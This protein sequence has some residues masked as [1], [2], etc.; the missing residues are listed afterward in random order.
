MAGTQFLC[1]GEYLLYKG[2]NTYSINSCETIELFYDIRTNLEKLEYAAY[3]T[4]IIN[5]VTTEN[6]NTYKILQLFLN[7]LYVISKTDKNMEFVTS[8][9][10]IRLMSIIGFKPITNSCCICN[11][12]IEL[13]YFS[14]EDSGV[15]C[16]NCG[17]QDKSAIQISKATLDALRYIIMADCKKIYSFEIPDEAKKELEIIAKLYLN[18]KLEQEY[19]M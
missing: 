5:D 6:Q 19:K 12:N 16:N 2:N 18:E 3:I 9:F 13:E 1:F 4:K 15:K 11:E 7:T 10:K 14:L 17:K 8:I